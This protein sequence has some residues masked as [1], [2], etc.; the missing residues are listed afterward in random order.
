[1]IRN[2]IF[3]FGKVLVEYDYERF[4]RSYITDPDRLGEFIPVLCNDALMDRIDREEVPFND[5]LEEFISGHREFEG[6][7]RYFME[8]YPEIVYG[9]VP[10][11]RELLASLKAEGFRLYGLSNW[12]SKVHLTMALYSDIFGLLDGYVVSS[13]EQVIKPE[14]A[15]YQRLFD[16][17]DLKPEEC[18]FADDK[19]VNIEGARR[20]GMP[21]ILFKDA[22]QYEKEL[23]ELLSN[24][25]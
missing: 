25:K 7:L 8:H 5:T 4:F 3:D 21:G 20:M 17:F 12:C 16:K 18:L 14:P 19:P 2:L 1:M 13:Q 22:L 23:R 6:E 10:G 24:L 11:M 9:E 15:I